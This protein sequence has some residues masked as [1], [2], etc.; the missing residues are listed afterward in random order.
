[1]TER[2]LLFLAPKAGGVGGWLL[3]GEG[4]VAAR[5][6]GLEDLPP[7]VRLTAAVVPGEE[8]GLHWLD[9]P[10]GLAPAQAQAAA[11]LLAAE[12]SSQPLSEMHV[13]AGRD[14]A[15]GE[16]RP[17]ALVPVT[18]MERWLDTVRAAG[19]EPELVIPDTALL[20]APETGFVRFDRGEIALWRAGEAAF[21]L[22]PELAEL[23]VGDAPVT[24]IDVLAFEAG[25]SAALERPLV[26]LRQGPFA[27]RREWRM[28]GARW[29]RLLVLAAALALVTLFLQIAQIVV[30]TRAADRV[31]EE[32]RRIAATALSRSPGTAGASDL[33]RRLAE[34]RGGGVGFGAIAGA[35]FEAVKAVPNV[36]LSSLTFGV[37][38]ALRISVR[39]DAPASL[40]GFAQRIEA[41]G[42]AVDRMPPRS[43]EGRQAQDIIV[44]PR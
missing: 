23:V 9:L 20:P 30:Y 19:I 18:A 25:L 16:L 33:N 1:M 4:A 6:P 44:R 27:R 31:Q 13:A 3:L 43:A 12:I 42:F 32:T 7:G 38:G 34:L 15:V 21:A 37:D 28:Q 40:D 14:G 8:V 24:E 39:G 26:N 22:E 36:E 11:R 10:A 35:V 2:L 5:G 41:G 17:V 29:R